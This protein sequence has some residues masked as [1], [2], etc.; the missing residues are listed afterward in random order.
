AKARSR[1][2]C[3][4]CQSVN[5]ISGTLVVTVRATTFASA[6]VGS[7][8]AMRATLARTAM[9][10][11]AL[12]DPKAMVL[13]GTVF[14]VRAIARRTAFLKWDKEAITRATRYVKRAAG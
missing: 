4:S 12:S 10:F 13:T 8:E 3:I 2:P 11:A 7:T 14:S 6:Q 5:G 9:I 1:A